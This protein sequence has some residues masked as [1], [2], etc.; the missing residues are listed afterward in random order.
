MTRNTF[1]VVNSTPN[2]NSL[3]SLTPECIDNVSQINNVPLWPVKRKPTKIVY[4]DAS[5]CRRVC[6]NDKPNDRRNNM[7]HD[8]GVYV[9]MT[10][11]L[12]NVQCVFG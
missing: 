12:K 4:S 9:V 2:W 6:G 5:D 7:R 10:S 3:V 8:I 1:V 11:V